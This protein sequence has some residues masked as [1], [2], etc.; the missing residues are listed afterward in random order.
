MT[1]TTT[2]PI[3]LEVIQRIKQHLQHQ[4]RELAWFQLSLNT[5]FRG[6]D[7][8]S[9]VRDDIEFSDS[10][11]VIRVREQKTGKIRDVL[12]NDAT[13]AILCSWLDV[14]PQRTPFLFEGQRGRMR[15]SYWTVLLKEW[16]K[17]VGYEEPRT[18]THSLRKTFV[19][20]HYERGTKLVTLMYMLNHGSEAQTLRYCGVMSE[21][22]TT[23]YAD[24][25]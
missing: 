6:G 15:T 8:L 16:C 18:A 14:H 12:V 1:I 23:V 17:A 4:P 25:I 10:H 2:K 20:T 7:I 11:A 9:L 5:A 24:A 13:T 19:K 3:P 21:D 22:V